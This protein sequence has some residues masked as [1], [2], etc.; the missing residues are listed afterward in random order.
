M[1]QFLTHQGALAAGQGTSARPQACCGSDTE[2]RA[3]E[4]SD[5]QD[6][7]RFEHLGLLS[8]RK[9]PWKEKAANPTREGSGVAS[10]PRLTEGWHC[11]HRAPPATHCCRQ[12][13]GIPGASEIAELQDNSPT[14]VPALG[15]QVFKACLFFKH[16]L[17]EKN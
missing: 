8:S 10:L 2:R 14:E 11:V 15:T 3:R 17:G 4:L 16:I 9:L 6:C 1:Y 12:P 13:P 7:E 5:G